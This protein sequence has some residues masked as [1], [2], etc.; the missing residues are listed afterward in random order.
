MT[1]ALDGASNETYKIYR[2]GGDFERVI[3]HIRTINAFKQ[4]YKTDLPK[5]TWQFIAFGHNEHEIEKARNMAV[6]LKMDFSR[7]IILWR[8]VYGQNIFAGK[9][10]GTYTERKRPELRRPAGIFRK[11]R[12]ALPAKSFL[13]AALGKPPRSMRTEDCW[14]AALIINWTTEMCLKRDCWNASTMKR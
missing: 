6:E 11:A 5:M 1:V 10:S 9:K 13:H 4:R 7:K 2:V 14:V 3:A 8:S 12:G